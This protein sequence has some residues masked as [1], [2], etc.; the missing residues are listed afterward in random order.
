MRKRLADALG[1]RAELVRACRR[2][3]RDARS[4]P[5]PR[6]GSLKPVLVE[7]LDAV[8]LKGIV[9]GGDDHAG[10]GAQ[11]ARE[12]GD[13]R[14]RHRPDQQH[15]DTHR[16]DARGERALEH[17]AGEA[18][19][20]ADDD[21][22]L[23]AG[24]PHQHVATA[25]PGAAPSRRIIGSTL[26]TPRTPSVPKRRLAPWPALVVSAISPSCSP[27]S[28][29]AGVLATTSTPRGRSTLAVT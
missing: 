15:V 11:A 13:T 16:A 22:V 27:A 19:V 3:T 25:R 10:V 24:A 20:L 12:K 7:E 21:L 8:V 1:G 5:R 4:P 9:R 6:P 29:W 2:R 26:A 18:R 17:V 14:R 28:T 23:A